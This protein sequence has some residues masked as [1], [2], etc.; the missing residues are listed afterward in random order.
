MSEMLA[1]KEYSREPNKDL[2]LE[3]RVDLDNFSFSFCKN[4][5]G[6]LVKKKG[7][8]DISNLWNFSVDHNLVITDV[9]YFYGSHC[10]SAVQW[11]YFH[12]QPPQLQYKF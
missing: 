2:T 9:T 1:K 4:N 8:M 5:V 3:K 7:F 10:S 11:R 6:M 12:Q